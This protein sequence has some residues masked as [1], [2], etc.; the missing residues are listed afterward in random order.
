MKGYG[1]IL[2]A[3]VFLLCGCSVKRNNFFSRNYHQLTTRYN[4]YFNGNQALKSGVKTMETKHEE[5]YTNLL[6][7]FVSNIQRTRSLCVSDM[8]Y[9]AEKAAKAIDNHSLLSSPVAGKI[10]TPRIIRLSVKRKNLI[11]NWTNVTYY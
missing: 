9:A 1:Y 2:L 3:I 6:P 10:K 5:D 11:T 4:V 8:D 7:V